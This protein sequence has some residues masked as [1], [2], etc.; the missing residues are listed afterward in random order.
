MNE[1]MMD[2]DYWMNKYTNEWRDD[3]DV[4][5]RWILKNEQYLT[6]DLLKYTYEVL[7]NLRG[8]SL[9]FLLDNLLHSL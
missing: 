1:Q 4:N 8:N 3:R 5:V 9:F 7:L 2:I 6:D